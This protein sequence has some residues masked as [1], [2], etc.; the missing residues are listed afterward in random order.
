MTPFRAHGDR[1]GAIKVSAK[2]ECCAAG[3][4]L[5]LDL[6]HLRE[7]RRMACVA[8]VLQSGFLRA[9]AQPF[10]ASMTCAFA[11]ATHHCC[12]SAASGALSQGFGKEQ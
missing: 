5:R 12:S 11:N 7:D 1:A 3:D 2:H 10:I 9:T 4:V 6:A 8:S